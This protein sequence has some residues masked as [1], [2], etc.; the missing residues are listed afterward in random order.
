M[1]KKSDNGKIGAIQGSRGAETVQRPESVGTI[2]EVKATSSVGSI[3][4]PGGVKRR[5]TR[6]MS[7]DERNDLFRI[8]NEEADKLF[9]GSK[10]PEEQRKALKEAVKMAVDSG[11]VEEESKSKKK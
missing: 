5:P 10:I 9:E 1:S 3:K 6:I 8:I 4:G 2:G 11:L 7:S